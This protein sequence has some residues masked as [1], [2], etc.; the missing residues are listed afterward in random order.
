MRR[1]IWIFAGSKTSK[2]LFLK[3]RR[4]ILLNGTAR[5]SFDIQREFIY[6]ELLDSQ[7]ILFQT[8]WK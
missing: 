2:L 1:S 5:K 3:L 6:L 7:S 8:A 4:Y